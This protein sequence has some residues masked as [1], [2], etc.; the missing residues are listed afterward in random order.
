[1]WLFACVCVGG[2]QELYCL[3]ASGSGVVFVVVVLLHR[4]WSTPSG[5]RAM[6]AGVE[7]GVAVAVPGGLLLVNCGVVDAVEVQ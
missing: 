4:A 5:F 1:M 6:Q 7:G 3:H 2:G